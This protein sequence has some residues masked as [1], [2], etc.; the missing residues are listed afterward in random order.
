M[1]IEW[2]LESGGDLEYPHSTTLGWTETSVWTGLADTPVWAVRE[3]QHVETIEYT[4]AYRL[5]TRYVQP[6][7]PYSEATIQREVLRRRVFPDFTWNKTTRRKEPST[8]Y[9]WQFLEFDHYA[10]V[11]ALKDCAEEYHRQLLENGK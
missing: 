10:D 2:R 4:V 3:K 6:P 8:K 9:R 5:I 7:L 1:L 11:E